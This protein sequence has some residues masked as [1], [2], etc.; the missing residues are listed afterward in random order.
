MVKKGMLA[1]VVYWSPCAE[2]GVAEARKSAPG[3]HPS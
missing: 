1:V 3:H 2:E